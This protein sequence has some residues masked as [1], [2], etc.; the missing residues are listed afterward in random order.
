MLQDL[1]RWEI[2]HH[3]CHRY[4]VHRAGNKAVLLGEYGEN[5]SSEVFTRISR[6]KMTPSAMTD[7]LLLATKPRSEALPNVYH[8]SA[9]SAASW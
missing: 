6:T 9:S 7:R 1:R 2:L 5:C 3:E 4:S 8:I